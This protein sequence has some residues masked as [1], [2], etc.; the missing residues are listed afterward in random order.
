MA[1]LA[2]PSI[3]AP[4]VEYSPS[5]SFPGPDDAILAMKGWFDG[6]PSHRSRDAPMMY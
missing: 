3:A 2:R 5:T 4:P 1:Y 6:I